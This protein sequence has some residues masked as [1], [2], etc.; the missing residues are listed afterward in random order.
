[1]SSPAHCLV[2]DDH[3]LMRSALA[4]VVRDASGLAVLEASNRLETLQRLASHR[5]TLVLLDVDLPDVNGFDLV[6]DIRAGAPGARVIIVSAHRGD[7]Y[8]ERAHAAGADAFL[9]KDASA[10]VLRAVIEG[11]AGRSASAGGGLEGGD[12]SRLS[13]RELSVFQLL[14]H[15]RTTRE[16][17]SDLGI[18][19]KTVEAHRENIKV[20]LGLGTALALVQRAT[21]WVQGSPSKG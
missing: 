16:I 1:V 2:V 15:G 11:G 17:A 13:A 6:K 12:V 4:Q 3:P 10:D 8:A 9:S 18:S 21:L 7:G 20:K 14:G 5:V 19:F